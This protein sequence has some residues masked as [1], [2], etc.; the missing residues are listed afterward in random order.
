MP[1]SSPL[2]ALEIARE[3]LRR[4]VLKKLLPTPENYRTVF[5]EVSGQ[6]AVSTFPAEELKAVQ[7]ALPRKT[8]KQIHFSSQ[9]D[10]AI[11]EKNWDSLKAALIELLANQDGAETPWAGLVRD[12]LRQLDV[13]H[14]EVTAFQKKKA[15]EH[16]LATTSKPDLLFTRIQ[17]LV[18]SWAK[19]T[20]KNYQEFTELPPTA[21]TVEETAVMPPEKGK[22]SPTHAHWQGGISD[23]QALIVQVLD[24][25]LTIV[26]RNNPELIREIKEISAAVRG[27][28]N[29]EALAGLS[30][31]FKN[32]CYRIHFI[33]EDEAEVNTALF[34]LVQL[35]T[36]NVSELVVE[37]QWLTGQIGMMRDLL[38]QPLDLRRLDE[39]ERRMKDVIFKQSLLKKELTE[40]N[41]RLRLML[42][43][44]VDHLTNFSETTSVYHGKIEVCAK[45]ISQADDISEITEVL[46]EV[47]HETRLVQ[48]DTARSRDELSLMQ[49]RVQEAEQEV[50]R[51][52][53]ELSTTSKLVRH[54]PL[55]GA[56]NRKGLDEALQ[57]EVS[58]QQRQ[59]GTLS[60]AL[61]DVDNFKQIND[62]QGHAVGDAALVHLA[63]VIQEAIRP[64]D[65]LARY[66]GEE[67]VVLLPSTGIDDA[68]G[69]MTR[70]QRELTRKFFMA[71][72][73]KVLI[74]FSCGLV[75]V[76]QAE[77]P[78]EALSR[79]DAAMYLAKRSGKNRVISA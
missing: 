57:K 61:L 64:Q 18:G 50:A 17:S 26:L 14:A 49:N 43:T 28:Q 44:F 79:A 23:L 77:D 30:D 45:K 52:K 35:I 19:N 34:R 60:L 29:A 27:A 5:H 41:D 31:R 25:T 36:D 37:D 12:L 65:T 55:T 73:D 42:V 20:E 21:V 39:V 38:L 4:L 11:F 58:R 71:N 76:V 1:K 46:N 33:A 10:A 13:S 72:N 69:I 54:D 3:T 68:V 59:G 48:M 62:A 66:G 15:L 67:F 16:I 2:S 75:N 7:V 40:A 63:T 53:N 47:M 24:N 9:L 32:L 8:A 51:L 56:L 74:T 78:Y 22:I 70:V 6:P